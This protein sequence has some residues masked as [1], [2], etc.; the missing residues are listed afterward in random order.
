MTHKSRDCEWASRHLTLLAGGDLPTAQVAILRS[1]LTE[2]AECSK[3]L[4]RH[5]WSR[6]ALQRGIPAEGKPPHPD[7]FEELHAETIAG[8]T[9]E[10]MAAPARRRILPRVAGLLAASAL[11]AVGFLVFNDIDG[12]LRFRP[13]LPFPAG[14]A[15]S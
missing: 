5:H 4:A 8:I 14:Q 15:S 1:H 11:F 3:E 9:A 6:R 7:F 12:G 13:A 10:V 2:C